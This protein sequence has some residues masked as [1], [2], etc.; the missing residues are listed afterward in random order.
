[1]CTL[2]NELKEN[3]CSNVQVLKYRLDKDKPIRMRSDG[4]T[5]TNETVRK[6]HRSEQHGFPRGKRVPSQN[7]K[8]LASY[9]YR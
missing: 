6:K 8:T 2:C 7:P 9:K 1:M 4:F 3:C 5:N